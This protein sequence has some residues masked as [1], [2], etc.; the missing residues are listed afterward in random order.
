MFALH[1]WNK[2]CLL[3]CLVSFTQ[4]SILRVIC[5]SG[6]N[7]NTPQC[8]VKILHWLRIWYPTHNCY[9]CQETE[10]Q[11]LSALEKKVYWKQAQTWQNDIQ[12][13]YIDFIDVLHFV[14]ELWVEN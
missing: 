8:Q 12:A 3:F 1:K 5:V 9:T 11:D 6:I 7:C 4:V 2:K 13:C 14:L 10:I